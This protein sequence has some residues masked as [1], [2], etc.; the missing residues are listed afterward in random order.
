LDQAFYRGNIQHGEVLLG[1]PVL[2]QYLG[3]KLFLK[4]IFTPHVNLVEREVMQPWDF[5]VEVGIVCSQL[6]YLER[7]KE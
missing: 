5:G 1:I 3:S 4:K 2:I 7:Y 6:R